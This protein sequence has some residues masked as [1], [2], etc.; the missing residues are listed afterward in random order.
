MSEDQT[1]QRLA[2]IVGQL[3]KLPGENLEPPQFFASYLQLTV[4]ATG[5]SGGAI[6]VIQHADGPQCYCHIELELAGM[7]QPGQQL[8]VA[9]AVGRCAKD[10]KPLVIPVGDGEAAGVAAPGG[11]A[12]NLCG[13]PLFFKPLRAGNQ[14]AMVVQLIGRAETS[15]Q[16]LRAVVGLLDQI[17]EY[18]EMY[19]AHR[20]A[21]V[22][23]DDRKSLARLLQYAEVV[24]G[25]L[26]PE[27]V[28]YQVANVGRDVVGCE[29]TIVWIDPA[30]KRGLRAVS[31]VDKPDRRAVLLQ[32]VEKLSRHCLEIK[33]PI[34]AGRDKLASLADEDELTGL[35]K[36]Y[37]NVSNLDQVYLQPIESE[38]GYLGVFTAEGF[39][40]Q[41]TANLA[42]LVSG[43]CKHGG[44]ALS[45]ALQM[46]SGPLSRLQKVSQ[47]PKRRRKWLG[48]AVVSAII[49]IIAALAPW[50]VRIEC[51]CELTPRDRR[52][53]DAPLDGLRVRN[54]VVKAG[55]VERGE[56]IVELDDLELLAE[57]SDLE[58]QLKSEKIKRDRAVDPT[59]VAYL[60]YQVERIGSKIAL[61][62]MQIDK[63]QLRSPIGGMILT[64]ERDMAL[65]AGLT[66]KKGT[67]ICEIADL[68]EWQ[69]LLQVPQEEIAWVQR[70]LAEGSGAEVK[71]YLA[72][73]PERPLT[74]VI[75]D[76]GQID[77]MPQTQPAGNVYEV[78]MDVDSEEL[79]PLMSGLRDG[80]IGRAKIDTVQ[81][82]L[83]YV[84][85]RKVIRF[86]RITFF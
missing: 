21:A 15:S 9:E 52:L 40:E 7:D 85:L 19:L 74:A 56:V 61:L 46:S 66:L 18:G 59:E 53:I 14:V 67:R 71:F 28:V 34:I 13:Y 83:G 80:S 43:V 1:N 57:R 75:K 58:A 2:E 49:L 25:S 81:R 45:N 12:V 11:E 55:E 70:G 17:A 86:F 16:N 54:V 44:S 73:Y 42:G 8:L 31:G 26:D 63:C 48:I 4:A 30:V 69:L 64:A 10:N 3:A 5:S 35:L 23:E 41:D 76:A 60:T 32:A 33:K 38:R 68:S 37:F 39:N 36:H 82:P 6:W 72:A 27:K 65:L 50:T 20:R 84:L 51:A 22:L 78:R 62:N 79:A 77:Q 24:H 47:D 29:R